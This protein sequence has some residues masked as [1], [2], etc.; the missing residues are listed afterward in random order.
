MIPERRNKHASY[1]AAL[2]TPII[3]WAPRTP[4]T[5]EVQ[6]ESPYQGTAHRET[7]RI[8]RAAARLKAGR[9]AA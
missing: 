5:P 3:S 1:A 8:R 7:G 9:G 6:A 2:S 4:K